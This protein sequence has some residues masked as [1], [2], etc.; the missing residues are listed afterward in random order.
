MATIQ[1]HIVLPHP[2]C[3]RD[4]REKRI[5]IE[6]V[7]DSVELGLQ[8]EAEIIRHHQELLRSILAEVKQ[9]R[10]PDRG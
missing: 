1:D 9:K 8:T 6:M 7:K 4:L 5:G 3:Y 10:P 2:V